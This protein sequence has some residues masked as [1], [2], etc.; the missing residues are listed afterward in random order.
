MK[1]GEPH[2]E[3]ELPVEEVKKSL[4]AKEPSLEKELQ[5]EGEQEKIDTMDN[6]AFQE[7]ATQFLERLPEKQRGDLIDGI[8][9]VDSER[10]WQLRDKMFEKGFYGSGMYS[11]D[12]GDIAAS[13]GGLNSERA[14]QMREKL[15]KFDEEE[16]EHEARNGNMDYKYSVNARSIYGNG[17]LVAGIRKARHDQIEKGKT[18]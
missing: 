3:E 15:L 16:A 14:W 7:R 18:K 8:D 11:S 2:F 12:A 17:V 6:P 9:G 5:P 10:A 4:D 1:E 13:L